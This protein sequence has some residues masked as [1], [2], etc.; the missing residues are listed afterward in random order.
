MKL[1]DHHAASEATQ[2]KYDSEALIRE[3]KRRERRRRLGIALAVLLVAGGAGLAVGVVGGGSKP[4]QT[5][6]QPLGKSGPTVDVKAFAHEGDL[7]FVSRNV[8]WVLAGNRVRRIAVPKGWTPGSPR[9]SPDG[10]WLAYVTTK[11][12]PKG[13]LTELW[14]AH[15]NGTDPHLM[16]WLNNPRVIGWN[17]RIDQLAVTNQSAVPSGYENGTIDE[18]TSLW[19]VSPSG[20]RRKVMSA[21]EIDGGAWSPDG[22]MIAVASDTSLPGHPPWTATLVAYP[23]N[24]GKPVVWFRLK[25][26]TKLGTWDANLVLPV[27]W[28]PGWGIGFWT[29][30]QSGYDPSVLE[31]G[32]LDLWNVSAPGRSPRLIGNTLATGVD[33]PI[34]ASSN[35]ELA[36]VDDPSARPIWQRQQVERCTPLRGS[37]VAVSEPPRTVS[38]DP[39]WS[40]DGTILAYEVGEQSDNGFAGQA[41]SAHWYDSLQL[42]LYNAKTGK[43][44]HVSVAKGA[45]SPMWSTNG[46]S[47]L[48][49][50][51]D[52]IWLWR[53]LKGVPIEITSPLFPKNNWN[54]YFG[55]IDWTGQFAWSK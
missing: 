46:K 34:E 43:S 51:N 15:A 8:L 16:S 45:V 49:V 44:E 19:L 4:V 47:L 42:W 32:G 30:T 48:Y 52:G 25:S 12:T 14:I 6:V 23:I 9:F 22:S 3:A 35:G 20:G 39:L 29:V 27:G 41:F 36:I 37:C 53:D 55:Q 38:M 18:Q 21:I 40:P 11:S 17:P 1:L 26:A 10:R 5:L 31:G 50:A 2:S 33:G 54:S 7:A 13:D 24:G 28:W